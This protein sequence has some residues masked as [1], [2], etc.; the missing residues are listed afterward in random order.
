ME[1]RNA[2]RRGLV[3]YLS[4]RR[5]ISIISWELQGFPVI[6]F[7]YNTCS[8]ISMN[9][10]YLLTLKGMVRVRHS[11]EIRAVLVTMCIML[12]RFR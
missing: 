4:S 3:P 8:S 9:K 10:F 1:M 5:V 12:C 7:H 6:K 11:Y 2:R